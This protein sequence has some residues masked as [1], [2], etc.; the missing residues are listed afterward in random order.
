MATKLQHK[1]IKKLETEPFSQQTATRKLNAA[2]KAKICGPRGFF[3][4][5]SLFFFTHNFFCSENLQL[6]SL[7]NS[8][9]TSAML[10]L[11]IVIF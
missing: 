4:K 1:F 6:V 2:L 11:Y 3:P 5:N 8:Y 7:F 10:L 9:S